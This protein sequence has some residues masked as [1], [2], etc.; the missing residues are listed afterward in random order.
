MSLGMVL[1]LLAKARILRSPGDN[2][3]ELTASDYANQP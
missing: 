3:I 1:Q 2:T